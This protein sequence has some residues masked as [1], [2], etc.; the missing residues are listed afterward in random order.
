MKLAHCCRE[1]K[2]RDEI[3]LFQLCFVP[4]FSIVVRMPWTKCLM[5]QTFLRDA[6]GFWDISCLA[7]FTKLKGMKPR[8]SSVCRH[9]LVCST[10]PGRWWSVCEK[11]FRLREISQVVT[12]LI[13]IDFFWRTCRFSVV[14][15]T[16]AIEYFRRCRWGLWKYSGEQSVCLQLVFT[17]SFLRTWPSRNDRHRVWQDFIIAIVRVRECESHSELGLWQQWFVRMMVNVFVRLQ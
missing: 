8:S 5:W 16:T 14:A 2:L 10:C 7:P 17:L 6:E 15:M 11:R 9:W 1:P 13:S 4:L 3:R 12:W